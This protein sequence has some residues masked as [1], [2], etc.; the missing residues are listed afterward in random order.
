MKVFQKLQS[1]FQVVRFLVAILAGGM[2]LLGIASPVFA[3]ESPRDNAPTQV[4]QVERKS[5]N[6]RGIR[7]RTEVE[8]PQGGLFSRKQERVDKGLGYSDSGLNE[9]RARIES[10]EPAE[11]QAEKALKKVLGDR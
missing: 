1:K 10:K 11:V 4:P 9:T 3:M 8:E 2:I 7:N 6:N 5:S